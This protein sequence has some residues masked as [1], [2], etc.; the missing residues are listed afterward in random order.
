MPF[1]KIALQ[2]K[3]QWA[4]LYGPWAFLRSES[5]CIWPRMMN[6]G[7]RQRN[8]TN[9]AHVPVTVTTLTA[10]TLMAWANPY[11]LQWI[12]SL[13]LQYNL[14][15]FFSSDLILFLWVFFFFCQFSWGVKRVVFVL[16]PKRFPQASG[17]S[18]FLFRVDPLQCLNSIWEK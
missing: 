12:R 4:M 5:P 6:N 14:H 3:E 11:S 10:S 13:S 1:T 9:C 2:L 18:N 17:V 15:Y 16:T 8:A 7:P